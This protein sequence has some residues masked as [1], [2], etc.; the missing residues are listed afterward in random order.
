MA[1]FGL[2]GLP[3]DAPGESRLDRYR[4]VLETLPP[5]FTTVWIEDHLQQ[6]SR[7]LLEGWTLLTY[8]RRFTLS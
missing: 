7:P 8:R 5:E 2:Q 4:N 3:G 1:D 6:A